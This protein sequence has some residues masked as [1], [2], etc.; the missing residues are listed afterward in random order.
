MSGVLMLFWFLDVIIWFLCLIYGWWFVKN[1]VSGVEY[2][3]G[4]YV[5]VEDGYEL[6]LGGGIGFC[7]I[8]FFECVV[9]GFG[10]WWW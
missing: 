6:C 4:V 5:M 2:F 1:G 8:F 10:G 3:Y 9:W 7:G